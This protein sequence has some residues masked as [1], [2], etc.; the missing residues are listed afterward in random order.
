M[1]FIGKPAYGRKY[2][3]KEEVLNDW[4]AGKDFYSAFGYFSIRDV[5]HIYKPIVL[6]YGTGKEVLV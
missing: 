2:E 1:Y 3:T 5:E 4:N 6:Q